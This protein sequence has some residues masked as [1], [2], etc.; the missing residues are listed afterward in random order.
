MVGVGLLLLSIPFMLLVGI[1]LVRPR[2]SKAPPAD[3]ETPAFGNRAFSALK[4]GALAWAYGMPSIL[5]LAL[6][7]SIL[8]VSLPFFPFGW[9]W[10]LVVLGCLI[11][12]AVRPRYYD[13]G[14]DRVRNGMRI[15]WGLLFVSLAFLS[16]PTYF[17]A[18]IIAQSAFG[19]IDNKRKEHHVTADRFTRL[20]FAFAEPVASRMIPKDATDITLNFRFGFGMAMGADADMRCSVTREGL[21][22]FAQAN[23]YVFQSESIEKNDCP[24]GA[25]DIDWIHD[26]YRKYNPPNWSQT[27]QVD[28][29]PP[30]QFLA[31]NYRYS[32]CGGYSFL[33]DIERGILYADWASN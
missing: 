5:G 12:G 15:G 7:M 16:L 9:L 19:F 22:R 25:P 33:Y 14:I 29:Y 6:L 24:N 28:T 8:P 10:A 23:G 1:S 21:D 20:K 32:N 17:G 18:S 13:D 3:D 27:Q 4:R 31:Y 11:W 30:K 26:A 2:R